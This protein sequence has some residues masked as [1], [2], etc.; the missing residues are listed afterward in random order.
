MK[1][2]PWFQC[3]LTIVVLA[4]FAVA[5]APAHAS[6][7]VTIVE[8]VTVD[9]PAPEVW[10]R[11]GPY[12]AIADWLK[13]K[14]EMTAGSGEIGSVRSLNG[15]TVEL[16]V[17]KSEWSYTYWQTAGNMAR[18]MYHGTLSVEPTSA[19]TSRLT[20]VLLYD[21]SALDSDS[22][23]ASEHD[24]LST[25]FQGALDEMKRLAEAK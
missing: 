14:C 3:K 18:T 17:G 6:D 25:R 1:P 2:T 9:R 21:Q 24:R 20:Y 10:K 11:V 16:M 12:C 22:L 4:L 5:S 23:R 19:S 7:F 13:V 8:H 15:T